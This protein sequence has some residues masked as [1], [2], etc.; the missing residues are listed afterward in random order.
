MDPA[1]ESEAPVQR[2]QLAELPAE[3]LIRDF[4]LGGRDPWIAIAPRAVRSGRL[5]AIP[6]CGSIAW[7]ARRT[8]MFRDG[9]IYRKQQLRG[10]SRFFDSSLI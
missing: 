5:T 3:L 10:K 2:L 7:I 1:R 6:F 4:L 8:N 9:N